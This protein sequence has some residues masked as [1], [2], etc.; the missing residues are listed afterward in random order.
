MIR[1]EDL[2]RTYEMGDE[3]L[4]AL[5]AV[6][7]HIRPGEHVAIMGPSGRMCSEIGRAHV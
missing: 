1:V 6:T 4:H 7:E 2:W 3:E 5:R